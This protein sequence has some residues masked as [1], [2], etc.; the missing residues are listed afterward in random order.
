[1]SQLR[2]HTGLVSIGAVFYLW[3]P[4]GLDAELLTGSVLLSACVISI[5]AALLTTV[6]TQAR[7]SL[8]LIAVSSAFGV[9]VGVTASLGAGVAG[10]AWG[11]ALIPSLV[12]GPIV[13][14]HGD[15]RR[16]VL[17]GILIAMAVTAMASLRFLSNPYATT[18]MSAAVVGSAPP[19]V[20]IFVLVPT[21]LCA[22]R[23][24]A[25]GKPIRAIGILGVQVLCL[26]AVWFG[27][28][29]A[30]Q[31]LLGAL[32]LGSITLLVVGSIA[33]GVSPIRAVTSRR[34]ELVVIASPSVALYLCLVVL[35]CT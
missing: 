25:A 11:Y 30:A 8:L 7:E 10:S 26:L 22:N 33:M 32:L 34:R 21:M 18:Y 5:S 29:F 17:V 2:W 35:M 3:N 12:T 4:I 14:R 19:C 24:T 23:K 27:P 9:V 6:T 13:A 20:G 16:S 15:F 31:S 28:A 1:V